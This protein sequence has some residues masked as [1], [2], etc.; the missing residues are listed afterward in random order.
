MSVAG[1]RDMPLPVHTDST[2]A[3]IVMETFGSRTNQGMELKLMFLDAASGTARRD[4]APRDAGSEVGQLA[5]PR[6]VRRHWS[7][8][9][10]RPR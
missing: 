9:R 2:V 3:M 7:S 10:A 4:P 1:A 6:G 8:W 5:D